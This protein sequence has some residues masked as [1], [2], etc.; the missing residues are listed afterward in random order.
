M[1]NEEPAQR[2][3]LSCTWSRGVLCAAL[4]SALRLSECRPV[5]VSHVPRAL[6]R[7]DTYSVSCSASSPILRLRH[8][9]RCLPKA[10]QRKGHSCELL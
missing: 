7:A 4:A 3:I 5:P 8:A 6:Q 2:S 10:P 9:S 1:A